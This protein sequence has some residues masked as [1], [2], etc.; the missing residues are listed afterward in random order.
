MKKV[1]A[2]GILVLI[3]ILFTALASFSFAQEEVNIENLIQLFV[4]NPSA[5]INMLLDLAKTNPQAVAL[6]LA[7]VA[8]RAP[9]L[10][11]QIKLA[12]IALIDVDPAVAALCV[13]TIKDRVPELGQRVEDIVV[14]AGLE[15]SY[16][17]AASPVRP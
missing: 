8:E 16:L 5:A 11:G 12:C 1:K 13:A 2:I 6:V 17:R 14:A 10:E 7:G 4:E 15:E 3:C 9:E